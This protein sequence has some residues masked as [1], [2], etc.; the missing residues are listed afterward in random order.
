MK[1]HG[2]LASFARSHPFVDEI[3]DS[4]GHAGLAPGSGDNAIRVWDISNTGACTHVLEGHK[5]VVHA[6]AV[7]QRGT[8]DYLVSGSHDQTIRLWELSGGG[9]CLHELVI[10]GWLTVWSDGVLISGLSSGSIQGLETERGH[11]DT[12][13][14]L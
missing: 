12:L 8:T 9:K 4:A 1:T 3:A 2:R 11:P 13:D 6:L 10:S 14:K 5:D 7:M